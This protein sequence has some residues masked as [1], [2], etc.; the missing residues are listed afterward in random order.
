MP[1]MQARRGR[2]WRTARAA[3]AAAA[4]LLAAVACGS[5][6]GQGA[7]RLYAYPGNPLFGV[8]AQLK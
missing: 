1:T 4:A 8:A 3:V 6:P 2:A 5:N 7:D